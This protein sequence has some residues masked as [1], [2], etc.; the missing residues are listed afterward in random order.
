MWNV[1]LSSLTIQVPAGDPSACQWWGGFQ[2]AG[3]GS[4]CLDSAWRCW[5]CWR[6]PTEGP[7]DPMAL[8][9]SL[10]TRQWEEVMA[11]LSSNLKLGREQLCEGSLAFVQIGTV[12]WK[13]SWWKETPFSTTLQ[14]S[15]RRGG[16]SLPSWESVQE[17]STKLEPSTHEEKKKKSPEKGT[18]RKI[19]VS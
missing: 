18:W 17:F 2:T 14:L 10:A 8:G 19:R 9:F 6:G 5:G 1:S 16:K 7:R 15:P 11:R 13:L 12:G 4:L 3:W